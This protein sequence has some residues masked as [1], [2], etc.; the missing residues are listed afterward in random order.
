MQ[1]TRSTST[2][3]RQTSRLVRQRIETGGERLWRFADFADLP[4]ASVAQALSRLARGG[5]IERLSKGTYYRGHRTTFGKSRPNPAAIR[6]LAARRHSVFPAGIAAANLLSL[7]TQNPRQG[8]VAT[9]SLSLPRKLIG[10]DTI[11]HTRRPEAWS[12]LSEIDA[13]ILDF[14][15]RRG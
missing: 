1:G 15:R 5:H 14:F 2:T 12:R 6:A 11:I 7:T 9:S 3:I 8:E 13:A 10:D 4:L